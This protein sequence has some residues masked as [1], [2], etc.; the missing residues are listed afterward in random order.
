[1]AT[2]RLEILKQIVEQDANNNFAQYGLAMEYAKAGDL[3]RAVAEFSALVENNPNYVA[4]YFHGGQTLEKLGKIDE[5][6]EFYEKGIAA[7][8][9]TGDQHTRAEIE[10]ALSLLPI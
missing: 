1:V 4:A 9:R 3:A 7:A 6:K 8:T 2:N 5:A 10:A